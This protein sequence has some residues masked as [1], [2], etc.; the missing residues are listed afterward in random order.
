MSCV[1]SQ[2]SLMGN[3]LGITGK[4]IKLLFD[5]M[6]LPCLLTFMIDIILLG[7]FLLG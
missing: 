3:L 4:Y 1:S 6:T 7:I 5:Y 2:V